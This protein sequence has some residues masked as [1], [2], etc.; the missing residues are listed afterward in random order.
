M[1]TTPQQAAERLAA[2]GFT[3]STRYADGTRGKGSSWVG[4]SARAE[5]NFK[6]GMSEFLAKGSLAARMNS[7]GAA[8]YDQ[9]V[10]LKGVN[11]WGSGMQVGQAKYLKNVQPFTQLW[12]ATLPTARGN[13]RSPANLARMNENVKRFQD[14]K[15]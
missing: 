11:N 13:K 7:A 10:L 4:A 3:H 12:A 9:G 8:S 15:R 2:A 6:Q 14:A 5:T 1:A